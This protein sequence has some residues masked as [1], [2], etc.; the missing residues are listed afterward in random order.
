M[1]SCI[2]CFILCLSAPASAWGSSYSNTSFTYSLHL[3]KNPPPPPQNALWQLVLMEQRKQCILKVILIYQV[4][5]GMM[6]FLLCFYGFNETSSPMLD[7]TVRWSIS[8]LNLAICVHHPPCLENP[9]Q[10]FTPAEGISK[11]ASYFQVLKVL[12]WKLTLALEPRLPAEI[13]LEADVCWQTRQTLLSE[14]MC[15]RAVWRASVKPPQSFRHLHYHHNINVW[16][17]RQKNADSSL[18]ALYYHQSPW[19]IFFPFNIS[20]RHQKKKRAQA[21]IFNFILHWLTQKELPGH[22]QKS[23]Y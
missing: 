19:S 7:K 1:L 21:C 13:R 5:S 17:K 20:W 12:F 2:V 3:Q 16:K 9:C 15:A 23:L 10:F 4:K 11:W 14:V 18:S 8:I 22:L 6:A